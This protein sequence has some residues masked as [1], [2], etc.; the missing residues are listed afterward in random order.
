VTPI[1]TAIDVKAQA[2]KFLLH[3]LG[4]DRRMPTLAS[5]G[6]QYRYQ[7]ILLAKK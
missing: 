5:M 4:L 6:T 2:S 7:S 1:T 3:L